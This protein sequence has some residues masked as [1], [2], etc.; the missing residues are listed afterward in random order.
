VR[1]EPRLGKVHVVTIEIKVFG[2]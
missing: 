2:R 1:N